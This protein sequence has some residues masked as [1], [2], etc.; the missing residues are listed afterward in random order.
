MTISVALCTYNGA[1][2]IQEQLGSILSQETPVQE[3]VIC[4][5]ASTD[6]TLA[7][8]KKY[9]NDYPK[10]IR[11]FENRENLGYVLNFEKA[12]S[13]CTKD[14]NFLCDQ[15]DVWYPN[16][17]SETL[18]FFKKNPEV[19]L[20]AHNLNLSDSA[21]HQT[22]WDLKNFKPTEN[23]LERKELLQ[24]L[25][26][27]GNVFPGMSVA[28]RK[29]LLHLYLPLQKVDAMMIHDFEMI[30]KSLRDEK[31]GIIDKVL[32]MYRKHDEQSIGYKEIKGKK[33][34]NQTKIHVLSQH[35]LRVK[36]YV[37]LF[38]L[39]ESIA[40]DYREQLKKTY[41]SMLKEIPLFSRFLFHLKN[42]Y[43]YKILHF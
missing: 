14:I 42:K 12:L 30:V 13:L 8:L 20:V 40:E 31:F 37:A 29:E 41:A 17:V 5:D 3:I 43:Y 18:H 24:Q 2:F 25:L 32:A 19:D 6:G 21:M 1:K 11:V 36:K 16:K 10:I 7:I 28:I 15:D 38:N 33:I 27:E 35:Y 22:F 39:N 34:N 26:I 9:Q 23:A 4:D